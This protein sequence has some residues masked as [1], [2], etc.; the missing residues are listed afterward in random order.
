MTIRGRNVDTTVGISQRIDAAAI[1]RTVS[2]KTS[3]YTLTVEDNGKV[4]TNRGAA[5]SVTFTLPAVS[6]TF[7]G[8]HARFI[9]VAA[10]NIVISATAGEMVALND[11]TANSVAFQTASE[12]IGGG[13][14]VVC[15]GTS[16][17]VFPSIWDN[18]TVVSTITVTT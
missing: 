9:A 14:E 18:G 2:A 11:A 3:A 1:K 17:L 6:S 16:W 12:I 5:G 13:F 15:D 10:Q 8:F 7:T 4:F